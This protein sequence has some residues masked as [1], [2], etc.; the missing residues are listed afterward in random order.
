MATINIDTISSEPA[1]GPQPT[2]SIQ[3]RWGRGDFM[4]ND[5]GKIIVP[6]GRQYIYR[7][8]IN[9]NYVYNTGSPPIGATDIIIVGRTAG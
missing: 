2:Q 5:L 7:G 8:N 6:I 4:L 3:S 1:V 9:G